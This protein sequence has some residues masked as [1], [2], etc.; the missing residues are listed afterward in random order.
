[1]GECEHFSDDLCALVEISGSDTDTDDDLT[2]FPKVPT[3]RLALR[4]KLAETIS[5][6]FYKRLLPGA[7]Q[8]YPIMT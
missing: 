3:R 2:C 1:M 7:T 4:L 5:N 6:D 8:N